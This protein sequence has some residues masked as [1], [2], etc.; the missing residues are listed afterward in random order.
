MAISFDSI[1]L[2]VRVPGAYVEFDASRAQQ[3]LALKP[4]RA[5]ILGQKLAAGTRPELEAVRITRA[6]Q[7]AAQFGAGS[8]LA[9]MA[10][11]WFAN[12]RFTETWA[13]AIDDLD[14]GVAAS[15]TVTFG[16]APTAAG[17]LSLYVAGRAVR[18]GVAAADS[19][20]D[21]AAALVAAIAADGS[22]P[23]TAAVNGVTPE[24]VDITA[25]HKG[26]AGN[27]LDL[28]LNYHA[29]ADATPAGLT[30]AIVAM[31]DGAGNPDAAEIVA[32]LGDDWFDVIVWPWTDAA[33]LTAI[34][35][36]L[37]DRWA[38]LRQIEG[39][40]I[41]AAAGGQGALGALGDSRNSPHLVIL[42]AGLSPTPPPEWAA[43]VAAQVAFHGANDPARPFQT[44]ALDGVLA[45][46][47]RDRFTFAERNLLLY[48]GIATHDVAAGG[49]V[50]IERL[51]TT[52]RLSAAGAPDIAYL[53]LTTMLTLG[54]LR[55][56]LRARILGKWPR[57]KLAAD[58]TRFGAGQAIVTPRVVAAEIV[59]LARAWEDRGLVEGIDAFKESLIVERNADDPNRLDVLL[60]PDLVNQ[61]R[62][63]AASIQ[64][65]L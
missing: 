47:E 60:R 8:M 38:G 56:T 46:A 3:G 19:A 61:F 9:G 30:V 21:V 11:A 29:D 37:A 1:P 14:A 42:G 64:F 31:A 62:V 65:L 63:A 6:E 27:D 33:N 34:E 41:A 18:V 17:T 10:A 2:N 45:P 50:R 55:Y 44:L 53:D 24:Q 26:L 15:G 32:A 16:G 7:A 22:L 43:A 12:N 25:R 20:A 5:L 4:Y 28:R 57:H 13:M 23:V 51:V 35:T 59:A 36:E 58:G 40:A 54:Y 48:D 52:Y 49:I 39:V